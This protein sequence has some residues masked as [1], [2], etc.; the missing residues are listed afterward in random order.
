MD[1]SG[2]N[3]FHDSFNNL[4]YLFTVQNHCWI[5]W[6]LVKVC[7]SQIK[8]SFVAGEEGIKRELS[9]DHFQMQK[10]MLKTISARIV[11]KKNWGHLPAFLVL[12][13]VLIL[14]LSKKVLF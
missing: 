14:K 8:K 2:E 1:N 7:I 9:F 4:V 3:F 6:N 13:W 11:N 10:W 5:F 12:L